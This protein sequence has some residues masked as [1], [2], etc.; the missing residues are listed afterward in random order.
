MV[1]RQNYERMAQELLPTLYKIAVGMLRSDADARDAVQQA[2]LKAWE[3]RQSAR[4]ETFRG[5]LTRILINE[6]HNVQRSRMRVF[7]AELPP[8]PAPQTPD[9]RELFEAV[10]ALPEPLKLAVWLKYLHNY[11]EKEA[12]QALNIPVT[13]FKMRLHRARQKLRETLD[14]EVMFE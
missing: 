11:S 9:Y 13:T 8:L 5:Y 2:L 12:A 3:K 6:C 4:I 14:R 10:Q 1:D 7:P